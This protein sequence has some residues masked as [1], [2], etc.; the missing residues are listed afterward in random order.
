MYHI[1]L[2]ILLSKLKENKVGLPLK[3]EQKNILLAQQAEGS[4]LIGP[5]GFKDSNDFAYHSSKAKLMPMYFGPELGEGYK[6]FY[7]L[8]YLCLGNNSGEF[9]ILLRQYITLN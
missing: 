3:V 5:F 7:W 1:S 9:C 8:L 6:S 2:S 4:L